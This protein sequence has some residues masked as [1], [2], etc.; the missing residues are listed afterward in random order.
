MPDD[1]RA[2]ALRLLSRR[3]YGRH[4]LGQRLASYAAS[5]DEIGAL[6]DDLEARH[7]LSDQRYASQR[8]T[9]R[10]SRFGNRR[11]AEEL[12]C[13]G[14]DEDCVRAALVDSPDEEARCRSVWQKKFEMLPASAE[15]RAKQ[16]R[17]LHNRGFSPDIIR[18]VL[19]GAAE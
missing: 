17:F 11:L 12:R 19:R 5:P 16:S 1:L 4:E 9:A 7:F 3:E 6:L 13:K 8:V 18:R 2:R 15:E 14:I 10:A